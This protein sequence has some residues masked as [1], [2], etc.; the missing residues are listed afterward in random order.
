[1]LQPTAIGQQIHHRK[2]ISI[3]LVRSSNALAVLN[4]KE[5]PAR[6]TSGSTV[7]TKEAP[8]GKFCS[9]QRQKRIKVSQALIIIIIIVIIIIIIPFVIYLRA[10]LNS[11]LPITESARI[12][13]T[14]L[15]Q[16]R[17]ANTK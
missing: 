12:Q 13:T 9:R 3:P 6:R 2:L 16:H 1:M 5:S 4:C 14:A 17:K 11:Q 15:R 10:E 8:Y 7:E